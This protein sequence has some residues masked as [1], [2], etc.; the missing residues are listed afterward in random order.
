MWTKDKKLLEE[1]LASSLRG[2]LE[3]KMEG[4]RKTSGGLTYKVDI[5]YNDECILS[6][7]E[8]LDYLCDKYEWELRQEMSNIQWTKEESYMLFL[9]YQ[10]K[11]W[12]REEYTTSIFFKGM[13]EYLSLPIDKALAHQQ[14]MIRFFAI[15]D[16]RCGKRRLKNMIDEV[17]NYPKALQMAYKLRLKSEG[18][19]I[20]IED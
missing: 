19:L 14:Y 18:I 3:Y 5:M 10:A 7:S 2:K 6:F 15:L 4:G 9:K 1:R 13:K 20:K 16:R 17:K 11:M 12:F 8:G